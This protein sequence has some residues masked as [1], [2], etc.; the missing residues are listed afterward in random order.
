MISTTSTDETVIHENT[1]SVF[2]LVQMGYVIIVR[3]TAIIK[4]STTPMKQ[5]N[6]TF[7]VRTNFSPSQLSTSGLVEIPASLVRQ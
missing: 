2:K 4:R 1:H 3:T 5:G 7:C 6:D